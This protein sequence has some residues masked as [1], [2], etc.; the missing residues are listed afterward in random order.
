MKL[1][2]QIVGTGKLGNIV[3]SQTGGETIARE[4]KATISNPNT[5]EQV[6][7]R[8]R[9]KAMSQVSAAMRSVI[10]IP[11][12]GLQS[13][14]N[15]FIKKNWN[16]SF[17]TSEESII[18]YKNLQ[19]TNGNAGIPQITASRN[20][21]TSTDVALA[22]DASKT[23]SRVVYNMFI[24][25]TENQLQLVDSV[26]VDDPGQDGT[27]PASL[28]PAQ[29]DIILY[30]YGMKDLNAKASAKYGN[31]QVQTGEDVAKLLMQRTLKNSDYQI[32]QTTGAQIDNGQGGVG[33]LAADKWRMTLFTMGDGVV[34]GFGDF[35]LGTS[36]TITATP[37][38]GSY[39][40]GWVEVMSGVLISQS[41][42][43]VVTDNASEEKMYI[44][45]FMK[46]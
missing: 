27:F 20:G 22:K 18:I 37:N 2:G 43:L 33:P 14:R 40:F 31:Y 16:S 7:T 44:A 30:A 8:G 28:A 13:S 23:L 42:P 6:T 34:S 1:T 15:L 21:T 41:T 29:G 39:F 45:V 17:G 3:A 25:S 10:V 46:S 19:L 35:N 12:K 9:F 26:V 4:Y 36:T 38:E 24:K 11:K 32:T 5:E